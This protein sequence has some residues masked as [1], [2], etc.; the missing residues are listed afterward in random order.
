[1][2]RPKGIGKRDRNE[3]AD[4]KAQRGDIEC[5]QVPDHPHARENDKAGP[6]AYGTKARQVSGPSV[7]KKLGQGNFLNEN[8][9][10]LITGET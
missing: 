10:D 4:N 3:E 2:P 8:V 5:G 9:F 6:Y 7:I 1:M